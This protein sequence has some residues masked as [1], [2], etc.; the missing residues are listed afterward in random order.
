MERGELNGAET[1]L[2][3][4]TV[5][6]ERERGFCVTLRSARRIREAARA[7]LLNSHTSNVPPTVR[8]FC[9][10]FWKTAVDKIARW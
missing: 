3:T 9:C 6:Q 5:R 4:S 1:N 2:K 10:M 7:H 8:N